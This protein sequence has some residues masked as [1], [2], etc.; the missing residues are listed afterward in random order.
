M[1]GF[2]WGGGI[3]TC[4]RSK[5]GII[6][7]PPLGNEKKAKKVLVG[8]CCCVDIVCDEIGEENKIIHLGSAKM[9][10]ISV[11]LFSHSN[12]CLLDSPRRVNSSTRQ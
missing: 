9:I 7:A 5:G 2:F 6:S 1:R 11:R 3:Q 12:C 8:W 10:Y 4:V